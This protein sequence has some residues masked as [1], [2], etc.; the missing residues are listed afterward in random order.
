MLKERNQVRYR[1]ALFKIVFRLQG[2]QAGSCQRF[3]PRVCQAQYLLLDLGVSRSGA[4]R[5]GFR[6]EGLAFNTR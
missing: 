2:M 1:K 5:G 6:W 3:R 4:L